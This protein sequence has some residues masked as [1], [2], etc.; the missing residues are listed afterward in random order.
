MYNSKHNYFTKCTSTYSS[1]DTFGT[2]VRFVY[3]TY[4]VYKQCIVYIVISVD[5]VAVDTKLISRLSSRHINRK[6]FNQLIEIRTRQPAMINLFGSRNS[7][8]LANGQTRKRRM[9]LTSHAPNKLC[10]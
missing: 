7:P 1:P 5:S 6:S 3:F 10:L 8:I 4:R 9:T 2:K